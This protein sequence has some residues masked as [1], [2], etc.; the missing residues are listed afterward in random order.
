MGNR[1][2]FFLILTNLGNSKTKYERI[3]Q[4]ASKTNERENFLNFLTSPK[5]D[6][7]LMKKVMFS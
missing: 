2:I 4:I 1:G 5:N 6:Q 7:F 3:R